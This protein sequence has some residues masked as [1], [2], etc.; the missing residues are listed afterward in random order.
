[1]QN[2]LPHM[3]ARMAKANLH[4]LSLD[5]PLNYVKLNNTDEQ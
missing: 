5:G 4:C 3:T 1:M 2:N